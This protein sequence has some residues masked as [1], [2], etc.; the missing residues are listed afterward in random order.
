MSEIDLVLEKWLIAFKKYGHML[1]IYEN[2]SKGELREIGPTQRFILDA[3][4]KKC[5]IWPATGAIHADAWIHIKKVLND[6]RLLYKSGDMVAGV[7]ESGRLMIYNTKGLSQNVRNSIK[8]QEW[9]FSE[10]Y[11][12]RL[13]EDI[14]VRL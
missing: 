6:S 2:P 11:Y 7:Q 13:K 3:K 8:E 5:Y 12:P 10:K 4:R 14:L 9:S 1:D